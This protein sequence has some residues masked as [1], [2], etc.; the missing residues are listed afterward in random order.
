[1]VTLS[2]SNTAHR[3]LMSRWLSGLHSHSGWRS[4]AHTHRQSLAMAGEEDKREERGVEE[5][6]SE[7]GERSREKRAEE[8]GVRREGRDERKEG[9]EERRGE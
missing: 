7:S 1:M 6:R 5:R 2:A 8:R 3:A 4:L 9:R